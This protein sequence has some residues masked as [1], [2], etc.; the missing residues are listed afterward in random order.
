[1]TA[2]PALTDACPK[3]VPLPLRRRRRSDQLDRYGPWGVVTGA[4]DGIGREMARQLAAAGMHLVLVARRREALDELATDLTA[5]HGIATRV[6]A[7]DL[8]REGT[9]AAVMRATEDLDI[10]L[11]VA[12]AGFGTSRPFLDA[13]WDAELD[14]LGVNCRAVL[15][16]CLA[17]GRRFASCGRGGIVL[18]SSVVA[19]QGVPQAAHYGGDESLRANARGGVARRTRPARH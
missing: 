19:F 6:I 3:P 13:S 8:A 18:M 2:A 10:G 17:F 7:A 1:M 4:S 11:L 12:A 16:L 15:A 14:M 5:R 9:P